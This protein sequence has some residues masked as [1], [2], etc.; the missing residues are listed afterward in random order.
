MTTVLLRRSL[1]PTIVALVALGGCEGSGRGPAARPPA[2]PERSPGRAAGVQS[3]ASRADAA[4]PPATRSEGADGRAAK[5]PAS[6]PPAPSRPTSAPASQPSRDDSSF[7]VTPVPPFLEIL[8]RIDVRKKSRLETELTPP[9][10]LELSMQNVRRIRLKREPPLPLRGGI[11][12][13][14]D[15]QG[16]EWT[17]DV[18]V[19]ELERTPSGDWNVSARLPRKP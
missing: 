10:T 17:A 19:V 12:L 13:R 14:I 18:E 3:D 15:G 7:H 8:E 4:A 9:D 6:P 1:V 2:E 5:R 16:I 11:V